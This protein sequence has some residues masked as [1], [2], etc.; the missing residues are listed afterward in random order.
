[1]IG[2][3]P[4]SIVHPSWLRVLHLVRLMRPLLGFPWLTRPLLELLGPNA[5][6]SQLPSPLTNRP[7]VTPR[8]SRGRSGSVV[9]STGI[10]SFKVVARCQGMRF[11][12]VPWRCGGL[13]LGTRAVIVPGTVNPV[14][15]MPVVERS[16]R[17]RVTSWGAEPADIEPYVV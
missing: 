5:E 10:S 17:E 16:L 3:R 7:T 9:D 1:M 14:P 13:A 8:C 15:V 2:T 6:L 4:P 11:S 12:L